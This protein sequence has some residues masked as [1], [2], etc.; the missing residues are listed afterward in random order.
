MGGSGE[1]IIYE[2]TWV[3]TMGGIDG[4]WILGFVWVVVTVAA[5]IGGDFWF[6]WSISRDKKHKNKN[7]KNIYLKIKKK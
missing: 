2:F 4:F 5:V 3:V 6:V 1:F 7:K